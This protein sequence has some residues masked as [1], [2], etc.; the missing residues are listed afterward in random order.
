MSSK[1]KG[2]Y[3]RASQNGKEEEGESQ[4]KERMMEMAKARTMHVHWMYFQKGHL[5]LKSQKDHSFEKEARYKQRMISKKRVRSLD[6]FNPHHIQC[7][8][9]PSL[10][11]LRFRA[12]ELAYVTSFEKAFL[13][14]GFYVVKEICRNRNGNRTRK[15][16][17]TKTMG[18]VSVRGLGLKW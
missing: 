4:T 12:M 1:S 14:K 6:L 17:R 10:V 15:Q 7:A 2:K 13:I 16:E 18:M 8:R 3:W 11:A 5:I 9:S